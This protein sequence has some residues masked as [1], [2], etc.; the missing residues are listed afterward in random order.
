M[1]INP[2]RTRDSYGGFYR[3]D[4][5][6]ELTGEF[7][8][9]VPYETPKEALADGWVPQRVTG[10]DDA[11]QDFALVRKVIEPVLAGN[12]VRVAV[13]YVALTPEEIAARTASPVLA[14]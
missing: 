3:V 2:N 5:N 8:W 10:E 13:S 7:Q 9:G 6:G 4:D 1:T 12:V 11:N 14:R